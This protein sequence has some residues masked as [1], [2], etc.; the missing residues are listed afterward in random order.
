MNVC[1]RG[2]QS[3]RPR[4]ESSWKT[5]RS[6]CRCIAGVTMDVAPLFTDPSA[7]GACGCIEHCFDPQAP[8]AASQVRRPAS[9]ARRRPQ[10]A[11]TSHTVCALWVHLGPTRR[12]LCLHSLV[13]C[14]VSAW[15]RG[16]A[17]DREPS[18]TP[19]VAE[20]G[21]GLASSATQGPGRGRLDFL[22][23]M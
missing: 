10:L 14:V 19:R 2:C 23:T 3:G 12:W 11:R 4:L 8:T 15:G 18:E 16:A 20:T 21:R 6:S 1:R 13:T 9:A 22:V 7:R 5:R 17:R